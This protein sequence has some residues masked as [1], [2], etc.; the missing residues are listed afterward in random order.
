M[1]RRMSLDFQKPV[2]P[3]KGKNSK[4]IFISCEGITEE[5]YFAM[6]KNLYQGVRTRIEF[7]SVMEDIIAIPQQERTKEQ[8]DILNNSSPLALVEKINEF[9]KN[10]NNIKKYDFNNHPNDEFWVI[11]DI[12]KH[13]QSSHIPNW[14][15]MMKDCKNK[16]Y[17][18]AVSNPFF[19]VWLLLHFDDVESEDEKYAVT[20]DHPYEKTSH[21]RE[22]LKNLGFSLVDDKHIN[23]KYYTK[24]NIEN[25]ISRATK[26]D[27]PNCS[28]YPRSLG[29][30]VYKLLEKIV[31][32]DNQF[33]KN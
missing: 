32:I 33:N 9:K 28:D 10:T 27:T 21:F 22:R 23:D 1:S 4:M 7:I 26:L 3:K 25:A 20:K 19:E 11:T 31:E 15:D 8:I 6:V 24:Q 30:T 5:E 18:F 16:G 29:T 12:D 17:S 2:R 14:I 13:T